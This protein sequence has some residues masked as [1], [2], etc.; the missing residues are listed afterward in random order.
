MSTDT[1]LLWKYIGPSLIGMLLAGSFSIVDTIFIGQAMGKNGLAAIAV[2]WPLIMLL[3]AFGSLFGAGTAVLISQSR[4]SGDEKLA[5]KAFSGMIMMMLSSSIIL[6]A[7]T[8]F[9]L[10][11]LLIMLG[12]TP[13]LMPQAFSYARTMICGIALFMLMTGVLE[14]VRNDGRPMLSMWMLVCGLLGNIILDWLFIIV[15]QWGGWGAALATVISQG[16]PVLL[17]VIYFCSPYTKLKISFANL[18][19]APNTLWR[20]TITGIPIFGNMLSIIAMLYMHNHQSL[21]YGQV[22]GLAAYTMVAAL[23]SLGSILMTGLAAG[24]QPL[25]AQMYGAKKFKR[26]NRIGVYTYW[27]A[28]G[29]GIVLM[30]LS[31]A[32][33]SIMPGWMGLTDEAAQLASRGVILSAPAFILLG[34]IRVAGF[35]YQSTGKILD[36]SLLI[37]GDA[38]FA[39]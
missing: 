6:G 15:F 3:G 2:T 21:R 5:Q 35:Y 19:S 24:M 29:F 34:V 7:L 17:G 28:F 39:L 30:L 9:F 13:D 8:L 12:A 11:P 1:K 14:V 26:Q 32:L 25:V 23:E 38:F 20:I 37:Y 27:M 4:G 33:H 31:F 10:N 18:K 16:I 36:S 22:D